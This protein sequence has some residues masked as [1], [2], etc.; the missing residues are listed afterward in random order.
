MKKISLTLVSVIF[1]IL[2]FAQTP[3][4]FKYQAV[5]RNDAGNIIAEQSIT[6]QIKLLQGSATGI[7]VFSETHSTTTNAFGLFNIEIG[8]VNP[9]DFATVGWASDPYYVNIIINGV[10]FGTSQLLSVPYALHAK[11]AE[12]VI[13]S[14]SGHYV[15]ELI[16]ING[17]DGVVF[18]VDQTGQHGLIC[19]QTDIDGGNGF[20][21]S[22]IENA[23][24]GI[25]AQSDFNG[26]TNTTSIIGQSGHT[27]SAAKL[28]A[29]YSTPGTL[30][31]DWYL[32]SIDELTQ[33]YN[34]K[35]QINKALNINSLAI[36]YAYWSSTEVGNE[37]VLVYRFNYG[38]S[39]YT[40]KMY[41]HR[42][43]A[44]RVF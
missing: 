44:V 31:G 19:S 36:D 27:H 2:I 1:S 34:S 29:D 6:V 18:Y 13:S 37:S 7:E 14:T 41:M 26:A 30:V 32:P 12:T 21:W 10:D 11:T 9:T 22:N 40:D 5:Y 16:G 33:I 25:T 4:S 28:C 17:E 24:I 43:R 23:E 39:A 35:Y 20:V 3:Q 15:G 38:S 8:S 42:I